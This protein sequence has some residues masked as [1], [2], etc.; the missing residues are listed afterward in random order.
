MNEGPDFDVFYASTAR[1]L[2]GQVYAMTGNLAEAE[3]AVAEAFS[4]AWQRWSKLRDYG[5][6]EGWVRTVAYRIAVSSWRKTVNRL[7]AHHRSDHGAD[8]AEHSPD[9][10]AL[11]A[12]LRKI[13]PEQRRAIVLFHMVGMT[14]A[15]IAAETGSPQN[16]VK[17]HLARGRRALAPHVSEFADEAASGGTVARRS[18]TGTATLDRTDSAEGKEAG[19]H[20]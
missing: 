17:A 7:K 15:E 20:A 14:V 12:A 3:D 18:V 5:D 4:R 10:L 8:V 11:V 1:R 9:R 19:N 6:P 16:T 2:V 13:S